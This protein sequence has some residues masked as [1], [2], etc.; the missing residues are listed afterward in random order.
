MHVRSKLLPLACAVTTAILSAQNA[1]QTGPHAPTTPLA[2]SP[3]RSTPQPAGGTFAA[4]SSP[5]R[6]SALFTNIATS[7]TSDVPGLPGVKFTSGS[8]RTTFDRPWVSPNGMHWAIRADTPLAT[9]EDSVLMVN[10]T[11]AMREGTPCPF[12]VTTGNFGQTDRRIGINDNGDYAF[13]TNT[14]EA[15]NDDYIVKVTAGSTYT[16]IA[17][18]GAAIPALAGA[19]YDDDLD[20]ITLLAD[21]R[22]AFRADLIDGPG[23]VTTADDEV[24]I[25]DN[26]LYA[27]GGI[28][29]PSMQS[30]GATVTWE[31]FTFERSWVSPDGLS[32]LIDGDLLG[33]TNDDV[34]VYN[35]NVVIQEG[36]PIPGTAF[37]SAVVSDGP[38]EVGMDAAGRWL[39]RGNNADRQ[40]WVV[41]NGVVL[42]K[43]DDPIGITDERIVLTGTLSEAQEVPPSGSAGTGTV[44]ILVDTATNSITFDIVMTN[45]AGIQTGAHIHGPAAAGANAGVLYSLPVGKVQSGVITYGEA[46]EDW[47]LSGLTYVNI[48]TNLFPGGAIRCQLVPTPETWDDEDFSDGFFAFASNAAG[49]YLVA[50]LSNA[51]GLANGVIV[52]NGTHVI[53]RENDPVDIDGNGLFDDDAFYNLFGNDAF[54]LLEDGTVYFTATLRNGAGTAFAQGVFRRQGGNLQRTLCYGDGSGTACPCGNNSAVGTNSGCLN[55]L[56]LG[57]KVDASGIASIGSDSLTLLGSNMPNSSALYFQGTAPSA[58]GAG[59]MFGDGLRCAAGTVIRLKTV[60]NV[61]GLSQYPQAGD[62]SI[63]VR[64]MVATPGDRYYQVWYRNAAAFCT[65]STFNLTNA[66][67]AT[68]GL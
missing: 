36:F 17:Q 56:G 5:G 24:F 62:L 8:G 44:S 55:S 10:G 38:D 48:H 57:G 68:W 66:V 43:T 64:G 29:V 52:L 45:L 61:G 21:G 54:V 51:P 34:T 46:H 2:A 41:R 63:S 39:A 16:I 42:A 12:A 49:D 65:V 35:G 28:T 9:S 58:G 50:G 19:T 30:G 7:P 33:T 23:V 20:S 18:E 40:D 25:L 13:F 4:S 22:V 6:V 47:I 59:A 1:S 32:V 3:V 27:R 31:N 60:T 67:R 11:L 26:L 37:T 53:L 14:T 15:A